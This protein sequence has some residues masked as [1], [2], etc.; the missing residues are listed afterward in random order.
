M[1]CTYIYNYNYAERGTNRERERMGEKER[2]REGITSL[3]LQYVVMVHDSIYYT[4]VVRSVCSLYT[5][6]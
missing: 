5:A 3:K 2:E 1:I 6:G 4:V